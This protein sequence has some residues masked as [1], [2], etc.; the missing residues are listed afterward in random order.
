MR[1]IT[2]LKIGPSLG[3]TEVDDGSHKISI[4]LVNKSGIESDVVRRTFT[5][6]NMPAAPELRFQGTVQI[7]DH[8]L[9]A[10]KAVAGTILEIHFSVVNTGD[11]D[12]TD[13]HLKLDAP[14]SEPNTYPSEGNLASNRERPSLFS[15][16]GLP[17]RE[18]MT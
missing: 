17:H 4:K 13:L 15:G 7:F 8:D 2:R 5:I 18:C 14:G 16:G 11:L 6:D 10:N 12:A 9:P 3:S 1:K